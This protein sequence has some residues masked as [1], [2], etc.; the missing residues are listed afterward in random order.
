MDERLAAADAA[1]KAGRNPDAIRLLIEVLS[2]NPDQPAQLYR[3][4]LVQLYRAS[5]W[6]EGEHWSALGAQ[7]HPRDVDILNIRGVM[8][9]QLK[10]LPEALEALD[11]ALRVNPNNNA[12]LSNRGNVLLDMGDG[13]RGEAVFAKLSRKDP[14]NAE[15]QRMLG[16]ALRRQGK[17]EAA[18]VR[19]RQAIALRKDS[20]DNWLDLIS[21]LN[22]LHRYKEAEEVADRAIAASPGSPKVLESKCIVLRQAGQLR[23]AETYLQDLLPAHDDAAWLHYQLG[24]TV[25]DYDRARGN[26]HIRRA[27]ELDPANLDY[28]M[29]LIESLERTRTGDEGANIEEA[30]QLMRA[31]LELGVER[32]T[33]THL[34]IASEV[35]IRVGAYEDFARLGTLESLGR[36]WVEAGKHTALM[37]LMA[38]VRTPEDRL[39]L[40]EL[41]RTWGRAAEVQAARR[42]VRKPPPRAG[43]GRIRLG[44]MS[45]DLRRH[46][47]GYFALPLFENLDA[48]RFEVFCYSFYQGK[49]DSVQEFITGKVSAF[50][51]NPDINAPDAAQMIADDQLDMLIELGGSTHM[52][53]LE[54][55]AY[56]A[57]PRQASWLGYPHSAGPSTIDYLLVDPFILPTKP[58]LMIEEPLVLPHAWYPMTP[59][60][61]ADKPEA[62]PRPPLT[63][64]GYVTFGTANNPYKYT[65]EVIGAWAEIMRRSPESRFLFIRP[66][67]GA[68]SFRDNMI[69][70]F[71]KSGIAPERIQF[72]PVRGAHM[73][74]YNRIDISLDTFPQTGGTTTC[75]SLWMGAPCVTLV[76]DSPFE[77]LSYSVLNN[78]QLGDLCAWTV[79]DYVEIATRLAHDPE[80]IAGLRAGMRDR[81]RSSPLGQTKAWA[82]D[83]YDTVAGAVLK[84]R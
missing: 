70:R 2:D 29:A 53:R 69:A 66:E 40:L 80:R 76:G 65:P 73:P 48:S 38:Q 3:V 77:R 82:D 33:P 61:F 67:G 62:A 12:A 51:W 28:L 83:F 1:L 25:S 21:S 49:A 56:R 58:G 81:I 45:S 47:V 84:D 43:D 26:T 20:V 18:M 60:T 22:E 10:R 24:T 37:K 5:R 36:T 78:L 34:K 32:F 13:V 9:R 64:N 79:D 15:F 30:Y 42:P 54:V 74:H 52:N 27:V 16:R 55:M 39:E 71:G 57:A 19:F 17:H 46:P 44:F 75:E 41:H 11:Q 59:G 8:L 6:E 72:E 14:R 4:L 23:R 7:R 35:L 50:R 31:A 63:E 68:K